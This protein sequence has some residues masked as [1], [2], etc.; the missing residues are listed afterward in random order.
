MLSLR[1][2]RDADMAY[3]AVSDAPKVAES[4]DLSDYADDAG[5]AALH[6]LVLD[7]DHQG[8]LVGIEVARPHDVLPDDLL[9]G[10]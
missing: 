8:R 7:F 1:L 6:H 4:I 10:R 5:V 2:D 3:I 9:V